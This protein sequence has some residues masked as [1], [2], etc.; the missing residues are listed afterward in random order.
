[1]QIWSI[2][3]YLRFGSVK[4]HKHCLHW[5]VFSTKINRKVIFNCLLLFKILSLLSKLYELSQQIP[6]FFSDMLRN[7]G[8]VYIW[9]LL[10]L[11]FMESSI[12]TFQYFFQLFFIC[13]VNCCSHI[14][15]HFMSVGKF[16]E[17]SIWFSE[18]SR[19]LNINLYLIIAIY[20][21]F[22]LY[23]FSLFQLSSGL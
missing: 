7:W 5:S 18:M 15:S 19:S 12:P 20:G 8:Q 21:K 4:I 17:L 22:D 16:Y 9:G 10:L 14:F 1:M 13:S 11:S 6:Q 3:Y 2:N 23:C